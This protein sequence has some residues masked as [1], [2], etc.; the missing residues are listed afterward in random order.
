M[1]RTKY[2]VLDK[3]CFVLDK[4]YFVWDKKY[5]VWDKNNFVRTDGQGI[6]QIWFCPRQKIFCPGRW[7]G[8]K[9]NILWFIP[10]QL[11]SEIKM[12]THWNPYSNQFLPNLFW[13]CHS[14]SLLVWPDISGKFKIMLVRNWFESLF[15]PKKL[16]PISLPF[17]KKVW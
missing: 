14:F 15:E 1:L 10:S 11:S 3:K 8:H 4:K 2:F 6:R 13:I 9:N 7:T 17:W 12:L 5:F 16:T